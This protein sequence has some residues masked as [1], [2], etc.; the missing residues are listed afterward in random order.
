MLRMTVPQPGCFQAADFQVQAEK[1]AQLRAQLVSA[2]ERL[3]VA[4]DS[5]HAT[6]ALL[7]YGRDLTI[8]VS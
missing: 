2:T 4:P 1:L 7:V 5:V 3:V 8:A 6:S